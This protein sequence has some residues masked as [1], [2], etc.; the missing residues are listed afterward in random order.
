[1]TSE[2][3]SAGPG[4]VEPR[5]C[6]NVLGRSLVV[7]GVSQRFGAA[8]EADSAG[9]DAGTRTR[10]SSSW[11]AIAVGKVFK[12]GVKGGGWQWEH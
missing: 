6:A 10:W 5:A 3:T 2:C 8:G 11:A 7:A 4:E 1:V 9:A 12:T